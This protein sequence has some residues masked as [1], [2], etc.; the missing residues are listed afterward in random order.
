LPVPERGKV[1]N[2]HG[3]RGRRARAAHGCGRTLADRA[4]LK[5]SVRIAHGAVTADADRFRPQAADESLVPFDGDA[6]CLQEGNAVGEDRDVRRRAPDVKGDG[7][8]LAAGCVKNAHHARRRS[9]EDGLHRVFRRLTDF[10]GS[11]VRL[12]DVDRHIQSPFTDKGENL[13]H[14][15]PIDLPDGRVQVRCG[16]AP[17]E[18]EMA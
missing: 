9:R 16:D 11:A 17:R 4:D 14:E 8:L 13:S 10:E 7:I 2:D 12:Q 18:V 1:Q 5:P 15:M 6:E 3:I